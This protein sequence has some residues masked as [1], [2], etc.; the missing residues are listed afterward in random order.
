[1]NV[2]AERVAP[3]SAATWIALAVLVAVSCEAAR[4]VRDRV[5][6][7][8]PTGDP[9]PTPNPTG[10][11]LARARRR[12]DHVVFIVKENRTFDHLFGRFPGADGVTRGRLC[13][14]SSIPLAT[15]E[16][17]S[18]GPKH[19]FL[20]GIIAINGGRM[21]C[22]DRLEQGEHLEAYV[23][24]RRDQIPN[25]WRYAETFTLGDRFF[26]SSYGPTWVE[27]FWVI[28]SQSDRFVDIERDR[29]VGADGVKGGYCDDPDERILSFPVLSPEEVQEV[30]RM[31]E[32][33][34]PEGVEA[35]FVERWPCHDVRTMPDL[36]EREGIP[37]AYYMSDSPYF[38]VLRAIP[39]IRFGPMWRNVVDTSTLIPD[40]R[41][42]RLPAVS[43]VMPPVAES[44]HPD[45]GG[46][47]AGENWT[48]R[49]LNAI[50]RSPSWKRTV[51]FLTWDDFGGFYD[52]EPP[53]HLDIYG[54]GA[55][56]PLLVISP[57]AKPGEIFHATSDFSS[58]LRFIGKLHR[59]PPLTERD[60]R[61]N[62]LSGTLDF[63]QEPLDPLV[64][65]ERLCP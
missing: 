13:D 4:P 57:Y 22:F 12:I 7:S 44:D 51:V 17:D 55:R 59:L 30:F 28:A 56:V 42:G 64:L 25:Y 58:V 53:P 15:A 65:E 50:M 21:N 60:R 9:I 31:E 40:I 3:R 24:Y 45:Y 27:H 5:D 43:W 35:L 46:L 33:P 52:H 2:L 41:A 62:D 29:Q 61:A 8:D 38:D 49:V 19:S 10:D 37:W 6:P 1:L 54:Y 34:D 48:V 39:H 11:Q 23:Q 63:S 20:S 47:C 14:G 36:L 16:D 26:S 32:E 18:L